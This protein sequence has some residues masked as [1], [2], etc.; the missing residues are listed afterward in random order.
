[1]KKEEINN[2]LQIKESY[3]MPSRLMEILNNKV[4]RENIFDKFMEFDLD[5]NCDWFTEYYQQEH[6]DRK[7]MKQDFTPSCI[8]KIFTQYVEDFNSCADI[9]AGTGG[10]TISMW[11]KN[12]E[13]YYYCEELSSRAL[14]LLLFNLA[15]RNVE[16]QIIHGDSLS[17]K[18]EKVYTLHR[19]NKYSEILT[20][21]PKTDIKFDYVVTNPPYSLKWDRDKHINDNRFKDFGIPPSSKADYAFILHGFSKLKD[22]GTL[23]A[24]LPHGVLF[25]GSHEETIRKQL[26]LQNNFNSIVGLPDKLFI[27]TQI[28]TC[29]LELNKKRNQKD[30]LF[31]DASKQ[32]V[33]KDGKQNTMQEEHI[34]NVVNTLKKRISL[35]KFSNLVQLPQL[36]KN[37]YNLNIP[38]YVDTFE[39]EPVPDLLETLKAIEEIDKEIFDCELNFFNMMKTLVGTDKDSKCEVENA[40]EKYGYYINNK[41]KRQVPKKTGIIEGQLSLF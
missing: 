14:P 2:I 25:R 21:E 16:G 8:Y 36:E 6:S 34:R 4:C 12:K 22:S 11:S 35:D 7:E 17:E 24:I 40:I 37:N 41:Q 13:A 39:Q 29:I 31:I 28:P 38:R 32:F 23:L 1:M 9:C 27:D 3:E 10:L 19:G 18:I 15:I 20:N 5:M 33:K 26:I 30:V